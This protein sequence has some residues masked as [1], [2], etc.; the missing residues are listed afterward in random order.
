MGL[1]NSELE[2]RLGGDKE[3]DVLLLKDF[4]IEVDR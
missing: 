1:T 3:K 2:R 4:F